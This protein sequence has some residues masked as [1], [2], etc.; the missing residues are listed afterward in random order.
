MQR[1]VEEA[2]E[3]AERKEEAARRAIAAKQKEEARLLH[4]IFENAR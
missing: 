1:Q 3:R 4:D 2:E